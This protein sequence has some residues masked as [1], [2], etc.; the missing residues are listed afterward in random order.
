MKPE[1]IEIQADEFFATKS[2]KITKVNIINNQGK[3][4]KENKGEQ[5]LVKYIKEGGEIDEKDTFRKRKGAKLVGCLIGIKDQDGIRIGISRYNKNKETV[6]FNKQK[7]KEIAIG[8]AQKA[9]LYMPNCYGKYRE[10]FFHFVERC[11]K[12]FKVGEVLNLEE[13]SDPFEWYE[14]NENELFDWVFDGEKCI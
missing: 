2:I 1:D 8:R 11:K 3:L 4:M 12:Y 10:E 7:A 5:M 9:T 13:A 14:Q 6:P